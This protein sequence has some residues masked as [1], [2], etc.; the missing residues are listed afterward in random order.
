MVEPPLISVIDDDAGVRA[1]L[2]GLIRSLGYRVALYDG[3]EAFLGAPEATR[4]ACV[5][6][7]IH[8][9]GGMDGLSLCRLLQARADAPVVILISAFKD[10]EEARTVAAAAG[11][12][13]ALRKPFDGDHLADCIERALQP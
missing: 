13:C 10:D 4:S 8:M 5:V 3:A 6:S 9:P 11:V 12:S 2:D 1:S 7:D